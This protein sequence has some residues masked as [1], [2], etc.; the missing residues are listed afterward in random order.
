M[1]GTFRHPE[2]VLC[3]YSMLSTL[4]ETEFRSGLGEVYKHAAIRDRNLFFDLSAN[5]ESLAA[6]VTLRCWETSFSGP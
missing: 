1:I 2:F 4:P 6:R 3:D 5:A